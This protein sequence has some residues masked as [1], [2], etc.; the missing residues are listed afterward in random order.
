[1]STTL[2]DALMSPATLLVVKVSL[3]LGAAGGVAALLRR[4]TSAATRH[5]IWSLALVGTLLLP[6]V[7]IA[8][9][10]WTFTIGTA[11]KRADAAPVIDR[12]NEPVASPGTTASDTLDADAPPAGV[13][14]FN[15]SWPALIGAVYLGGVAVILI[16][17]FVQRSSERR[18]ARRASHV[19]DPEWTRL[20]AECAR[21][22]GVRSEVRLLRSREQSMPMTFGIRR[23]SILIPALAQ[24]WTGDRRRA[25]IM[26]ELA[27]IARRDCPGRGVLL[28]SGGKDSAVLLRLAGKAFH[29]A[30]LPF[31]VMHVDTGHNFPEVIEYRDQVV[32]EVGAELIVANVQD[33]ID[34]GRVTEETGPRASR[35]RLQTVTLLDAIEEY[36]FEAAF[37]GARRDEERARAKER[38]MSFRDDF[39][40]WDP[41][42]QR[43]E[44]WNLYNG[45]IKPGEHV[46]VFP[47]SN[48]TELDVWQYIQEEKID[49][50]VDLLRARARGLRPRRDALRDLGFIEPCRERTRSPSR[51]A[52]ARSA[53]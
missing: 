30:G 5:L 42:N 21:S 3:L 41:K 8:L 26:H 19:R 7:S 18:C 16:A 4:R 40:Q 24:T 51:S 29:P 10:G 22:M 23:P 39:G 28:F 34:S 31:P 44:L 11:P 2:L 37:G 9:P 52:S 49:L 38:I 6:M 33:S 45:V 17:L 48:W 13:R 25:V 43:P 47:L 15:L 27:H 20:L 14:R 36:G 1:M 50:P 35:N 46:R 12:R 53:T 32:A